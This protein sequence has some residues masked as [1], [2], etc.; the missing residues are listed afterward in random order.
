MSTETILTLKRIRRFARRTRDYRRT[1]ALLGG[2]EDDISELEPKYGAEGY[3]LIEKMVA[4]CKAHCNI[5]D[6]CVNFLD[7]A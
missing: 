2:V 5:V 3:K 6:M 4:T 7:T 1:Y